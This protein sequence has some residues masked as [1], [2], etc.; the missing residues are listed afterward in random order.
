MGVQGV[1]VLTSL[2]YCIRR[3]TV[4]LPFFS[5]GLQQAFV[6]RVEICKR[7]EMTTSGDCPQRWI[8][9]ASIETT[10]EN[11]RIRT[12]PSKKS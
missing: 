11:Q 1:V 8:A 3:L 12:Y 10:F 9:H 4:S 2:S 5:V 7:R 6:A